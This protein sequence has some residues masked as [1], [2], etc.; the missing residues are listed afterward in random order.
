M[1]LI[2][3]KLI[4]EINPD[5]IRTILA[6]FENGT[7]LGIL[8]AVGEWGRKNHSLKTREEAIRMANY[9]KE[10]HSPFYAPLSEYEAELNERAAQE[11]RA[12]T[13][14]SRI[15]TEQEKSL[16]SNSP[17]Q[18]TSL[19]QKNSKIPSI[20][21][22]EDLAIKRKMESYTKEEMEAISNAGSLEE[23]FNQGLI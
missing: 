9:N 6:Y 14:A 21:S 4:I 11:R 15:R 17:E 10:N 3:Q 20:A 1:G 18:I 13:K 5:D 8:T 16:H 22:Q 7:E 2:G 12:R 23:A 19:K